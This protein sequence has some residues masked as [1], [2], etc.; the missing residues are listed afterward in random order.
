GTGYGMANVKKYIEQHKGSIVI[1]SKMGRGTKISIRL[2]VIKKELSEE[3]I[4][5]IKKTNFYVEKNILLVENEKDI[6]DVQYKILTRKPCRHK[7]DI[8]VTGKAAMDLFDSNKYDFVSLDYVLTGDLNGMDVYKH[9]RQTN[10]V[11]PILFVSGNL[12]FLESI[13]DLKYNDP[14]VDHVSKPCHNKNYIDSI[15]VLLETA[16]YGSNLI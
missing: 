5:E 16:E 14:Y 7:V 9:I 12:D 2:P 11:I 10:T 1:D 4:I 6:S 15:N 8:A 3:V 13:K